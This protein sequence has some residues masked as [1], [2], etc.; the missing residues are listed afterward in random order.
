MTAR[1]GPESSW[2]VRHFSV[3][4][5]GDWSTFRT[6]LLVQAGWGAK[7]AQL[8]AELQAAVAAADAARAEDGTNTASAAELRSRCS[9]LSLQLSDLMS[10]TVAKAE[11]C[12]QLQA[13]VERLAAKVAGERTR[14]EQLEA[15]VAFIVNLLHHPC[16]S[17][18]F[19]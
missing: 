3:A 19:M 1:H 4:S 18:R 14:A 5:L 11:E 6:I 10:D 7:E 2:H 12:A 17:L 9:E 16:C 13:A 15:Q 8:Q